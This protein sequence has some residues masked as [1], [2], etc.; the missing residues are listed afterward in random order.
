MFKVRGFARVTGHMQA[1]ARLEQSTCH[2]I[3]GLCPGTH[4]GRSHRRANFNFHMKELIEETKE[5]RQKET[6]LSTFLLTVFFVFFLV[7]SLQRKDSTMNAS[8]VVSHLTPLRSFNA[9]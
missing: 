4:T 8:S 6:L 9:I 7:S 1:R 3:S 2:L 5:T